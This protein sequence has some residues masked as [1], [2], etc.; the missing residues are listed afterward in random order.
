MKKRLIITGVILLLIGVITALTMT[1]STPKEDDNLTTINLAEV[2]H[3]IF[4]APQYA[5]IQNG[6]FEEEGMEIN[7][8][9][10]P[11]ADKVAA[12][13]LSKDADIGLSGSEATIYVYNGGEQ[14]YLKT[15]AQLTQKDGSFL[16]SR[17]PIEN[18]T[19]ED[20]RGKTVIG[21]R[22]GGM[23]EMT[24]E[25]VLRQNGMDPKTDLTIDTS[26]EF[27][28]MGGA[29]IGGDDDFVTLFEPTALEVEQQG[30]GYVVAS[31]GELGGVVPYTSYSA[32][33]S[34]IE[35]NPDLIAGFNRAVQKG[36]DY[37]HS[38]SDEEVAETILSFFPDTSLNDLTEVVGRYREID[39]WPTTTSFTEESFNHL[40]DIMIDAGE[41]EEKVPYSELS[42]PI[43]E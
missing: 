37:V 42:Y 25:Y 11:G 17:T 10:T 24:F 30:Y 38:H 12:A 20:L 32:R 31:I 9:L 29:F 40:Q 41:L 22:R 1:F 6:Y 15:F 21:G 5:A 36:L 8:I 14:D 23:P 33:I 3:T 34:F 39:A 2:S 18:F 7:L 19:L 26:V 16:V 35:E 13:L 43:S 4:Y 28:A 27:A